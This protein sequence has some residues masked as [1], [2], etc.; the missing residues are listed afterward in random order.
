[1]LG[2]I[3]GKQ[4]GL[5]HELAPEAV[6]FAMLLNPANPNSPGEVAD[7]RDAASTLGRTIEFVPASSAQEIV[8][9]F[10]SL[11]QKRIDALLVQPDP[12]F[13][14]RR[15]ELALLAAHAATPAIYGERRYAEAGGL[16]SY[17]PSL[18]EQYR[19]VGNYT[20]RVLKGEKPADLPVQQPTKFE[21]II[22]LQAAMALGVAV[23]ST[24]LAVADEVIE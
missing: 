24:L 16:M 7:V 8:A 14:A 19:Q 22:N 5:L 9:G 13:A 21:L 10:A 1:M 6:R 17:G 18:A 23:P 12:M 4:F 11:A 3:A 15:T 2:E 20:G